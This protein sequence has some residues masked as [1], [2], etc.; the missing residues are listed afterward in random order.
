MPCRV[1]HDG[2]IGVD[3]RI[4]A[5]H[6]ADIVV[7]D[8]KRNAAV[9]ITATGHAPAVSQ[10]PDVTEYRQEFLA[11]C[12]KLVL[13]FPRGKGGPF[14]VRVHRRVVSLRVGVRVGLKVSASIDNRIRKKEETIKSQRDSRRAR[15]GVIPG[16]SLGTAA[17]QGGAGNEEEKDRNSQMAHGSGS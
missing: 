2:R 3:L 7:L 5:G 17:D 9:R 16:V 4:A 15:G 12:A 10:I 6:V 11:A 13:G 1:P 14:A 8:E